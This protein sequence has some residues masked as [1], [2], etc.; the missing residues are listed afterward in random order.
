MGSHTQK[1]MNI[2]HDLTTYTN[3]T[4]QCSIDLKI[5]AKTETSWA[6]QEKIIDV[7]FKNRF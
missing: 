7:G 2:N 5:R 3:K 1:Q 6:K 4:S